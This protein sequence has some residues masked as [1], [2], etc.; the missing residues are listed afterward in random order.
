M[1][2]HLFALVNP[3]SVGQQ[4]LAVVFLTS[5]DSLLCPADISLPPSADCVLPWTTI[6]SW[7]LSSAFLCQL[8]LSVFC[9]TL[10][11][12]STSGL[13]RDLAPGPLCGFHAKRQKEIVWVSSTQ[14]E[15]NCYASCHIC[16]LMEF[17]WQQVSSG[18]QDSSHYSSRSQQWWSS[19]SIDSPL[20]SNSPCPSSASWGRLQAQKVQ[21]A[22]T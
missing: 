16:L 2:I 7:L 20:I 3:T 4:V 5:V 9:R 19:D 13:V 22:Q 17:E 11:P 8:A 6:S 12:S 18:L 10:L 21:L 14:T 1:L 15:T